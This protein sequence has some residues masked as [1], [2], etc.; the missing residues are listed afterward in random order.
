MGNQTGVEPG[1]SE[2]VEQPLPLEIA[3]HVQLG[4]LEPAVAEESAGHEERVD[5]EPLIDPIGDRFQIETT[6]ESVGRLAAAS[7]EERV[8]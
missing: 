1:G 2:E 5:S 3:E 4:H 7:N 8:R 6:S